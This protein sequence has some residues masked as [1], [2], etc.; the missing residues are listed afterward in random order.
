MKKYPILFVLVITLFSCS[1]YQ[2]L[3]K[4]DDAELKYARAIEYFEKGDYMRAN[5]LFDEVTAYYRGTERSETLLNYVARSYMGQKDYFT[6]SEYYKAYVRTY[7]K[8]KYVQESKYMIGYCYYLDSPDARLDQTSTKNAID[9]LQEFV[10]IY[11]ENEHVAEANRLIDEM[12]D[13]LAYKEYMN[14]RLYYNL[15]NYLGNNYLSAVIAAQNALKNYPSTKYREDLS[16]IILESKYQQAV[17]SIQERLMER[18]ME[19]IDEYYSFI[20]EFPDGKHR[21]QADRIF[22]ESKK[23]VKD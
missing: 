11:P 17:Q 19:T 3:L 21:R 13:K 16:M 5:T 9:A 15:G 1:E 12:K 10:D 22:R 20:N 4:S 7:P 2:K 23:I 8:S 18:Y 6:A 14:A